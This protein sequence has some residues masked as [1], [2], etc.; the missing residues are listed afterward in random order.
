MESYAAVRR[1]VFVKGHSRREAVSV[2][3]LSR[4]TVRKMCLYLALPGYRRTKPPTKLKLEALLPVIE[5]FMD[6]GR[7]APGKQ[8]HT[9]K[10]ISKCLRDNHELHDGKGPCAA[11]QGE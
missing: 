5:A 1:F 9:A 8:Q 7:E 10:R 11:V 3:W 4:D 2:F 6:A